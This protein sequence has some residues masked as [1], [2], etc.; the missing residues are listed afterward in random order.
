MIYEVEA[1]DGR[2]LEIE[3]PEG[4]T[5]QEVQQAA[6]QIYADFLARAKALS[7]QQLS[8][9]LP[10]ADPDLAAFVY[11]PAPQPPRRGIGETLVGAG[12]TAL[13]LATGIPAAVTMPV[14]ALGGLAG[15]VMSGEYGTP[16]GAQRVA[17]AAQEA[18]G[19][20][21]Y[22]P[23]TEAGREMLGAVG[24]AASVIPPV[25]PMAPE[26]AAAT[27]L[28]RPT[29]TR[30]AVEAERAGQQLAT[31]GR[32]AVEQVRETGARMKA[33]AADFLMPE[34]RA[35]IRQ[36]LQNEPDS[37]DVVSYRL[38]N[39]Q[40][41]PDPAAD[42]AL[43]QGWKEGAVASIKAAS[44][45]DRR[46]M[47][48]MLNIYKTGKKSERFRV[49]NRPADIIGKSLDDRVK[50]INAT[51]RQAGADLERV[52]EE[53]LRGSQVNYSP[54]VNKLIDDLNQIGVKIEMDESGVARANLRDSDIQ[55]DVKAQRILNNVLKRI[56]DVSAPD[57]YGVHKAK[58]FIDTQVSYGKQP[59]ANPLSGTAERIVKDFRANLN[60]A[61]GEEFPDYREVNTRYSETKNALTDL[62][63]AV[64]TRLDFDSPN[65]PAQFGTASRKILSNYASR[66]NMLD[67][68]DQVEGT[69]RKYGMRFNDDILNQL[70]FVNELD[71]MFGAPAD[72]TF[73]GQISQALQTGVDVARG[74]VAQRA[75]DLLSDKF[76]K[77]RGVNEENAIKSMEDI[78]N[79]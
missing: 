40:V 16:Q 48:Q 41:R 78:L 33:E 20:T 1:P 71:R 58:Q 39:D 11:G 51:R 10:I 46:R 75:F 28:A 55:G 44:D 9:E 35:E 22:Q 21:M 36:I 49:K 30:G 57:A 25:M 54:A 32:E 2:I 52:A 27:R 47:R 24:E 5:E 61:L 4:A 50:F 19:L 69:A 17:Q 53:Q 12:E 29:I 73:K 23:R 8:G 14:G 43:K 68:L 26:L 42:K 15:A 77:M 7:P 3:G 79:R 31:T 37:T 72:M 66:A 63:K 62:Q 56:S 70:I 60:N 67:A 76:E 74:N 6:A 18:A 13:S 34:R 45:E 64:G 38:V 65:A 59:Q